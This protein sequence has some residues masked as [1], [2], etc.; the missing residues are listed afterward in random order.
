MMKNNYTN[1]IN[2]DIVNSPFK[3]IDWNKFFG[4][5]YF[6]LSWNMRRKESACAAVDSSHGGSDGEVVVHH[7]C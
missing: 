5:G 6:F 1:D 2:L 7:S 4:L 3:T